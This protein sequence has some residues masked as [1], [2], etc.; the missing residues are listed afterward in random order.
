MTF[1]S[2]GWKIKFHIQVVI[3][4]LSK[5]WFLCLTT[6]PLFLH[7]I[8]VAWSLSISLNM[9]YQITRWM[10]VLPKQTVLSLFIL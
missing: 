10:Q 3:T 1:L 4:L 5:S 9:L 2:S 8:Q 7:E 6:K